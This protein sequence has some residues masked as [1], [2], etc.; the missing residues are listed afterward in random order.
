[1]RSIT[2]IFGLIGISLATPVIRPRVLG[3]RDA[4]PHEFPYLVS[5]AD[6]ETGLNNCGGT[7]ISDRYVLTAGHCI[8]GYELTDFII[9]AG[10]HNVSADEKEEQIRHPAKYIVHNDFSPW[11]VG[12][13]DIGLIELDKPFEINEFVKPI[14]HLPEKNAV[15]SGVG[16]VSGWGSVSDTLTARFPDILQTN[17]VPI[18]P[19]QVCI[20][21]L[22]GL[23]F[24]EGQFCTGPLTGKIGHCSGDSGG[25]FVQGEP[26][27]RTLIGVVS[28]NYEPCG[29]KGYPPALTR[30]SAFVNWIHKKMK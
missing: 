5:I 9:K 20:D 21:N 1:M 12:P 3:G 19:N 26:G 16:T 23:E 14:E 22:E 25:P 27:N 10:K 30:V 17:D 29:S 2:V 11:V 6:S 4:V 13:N 7:I 24:T 15:P 28:F 8:H 18:L